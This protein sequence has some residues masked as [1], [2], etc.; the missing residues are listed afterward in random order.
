M[1]CA[2]TPRE[3]ADRAAARAV[4]GRDPLPQ[5]PSSAN[6]GGSRE[7]SSSNSGTKAPNSGSAFELHRVLSRDN[8]ASMSGANGNGSRSDW[9]VPTTARPHRVMDEQLPRQAGLPDPGLTLD[10]H[11]G[12][13]RGDQLE[14]R[15]QRD[16]AVHQRSWGASPVPKPLHHSRACRP[17][18]VAEEMATT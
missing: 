11:D 14:Q 7:P 8:R 15:V 17:E 13:L 10:P 12:R 3:R 9:H 18:V 1:T 2:T 5:I 16:S 4:D 6:P